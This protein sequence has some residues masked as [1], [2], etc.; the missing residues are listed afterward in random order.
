MERARERGQK[1]EREILAGERERRGRE[2]R[3]ETWGERVIDKENDIYGVR[4]RVCLG[5]WDRDK[6][7]EMNGDIDMDG[8]WREGGIFI[9]LDG[10]I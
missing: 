3:R 7:Q 4:E 8:G 9:S 2:G 5:G 10:S 1:E 6:N